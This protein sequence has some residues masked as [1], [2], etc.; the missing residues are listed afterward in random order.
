MILNILHPVFSFLYPD[1][2]Q[3]EVHTNIYLSGT[4]KDGKR[5][6]DLE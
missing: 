3:V 6:N 2:F 1:E 4:V 5:C